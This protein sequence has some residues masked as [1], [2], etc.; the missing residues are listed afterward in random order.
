M[1]LAL[2]PLDNVEK[3]RLRN[4]LLEELMEF[5]VHTY[6]GQSPN[7]ERR[8]GKGSGRGGAGVL[9]QYVRVPSGTNKAQRCWEKLKLIRHQRDSTIDSNFAPTKAT[10]T[11]TPSSVT[12]IRL[13]RKALHDLEWPSN[14]SL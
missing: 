14:M 2:L 12:E 8:S 13:G 4:A 7:P 3:I 6:V 1:A 11:D 5:I 10:P 9:E